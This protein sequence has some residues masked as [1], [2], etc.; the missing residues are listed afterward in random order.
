MNI[1]SL[2]DMTLA[3]VNRYEKNKKKNTSPLKY[4]LYNF[5]YNNLGRNINDSSLGGNYIRSISDI[6]ILKKTDKKVKSIAHAD[7][8]LLIKEINS[9]KKING[10]TF[11]TIL[12]NV[13]NPEGRFKNS[14]YSFRQYTHEYDKFF[15][16][17]GSTSGVDGIYLSYSYK[18]HENYILVIKYDVKIIT[19]ILNKYGETNEENSIFL[20]NRQ[21]LFLYHTLAYLKYKLMVNIDPEK[22]KDIIT[23]YPHTR[24]DRL[25]PPETTLCSAIET[26]TE[27][28]MKSLHDS[29]GRMVM[30]RPLDQ[31]SDLVVGVVITDKKLF[32]ISP[33]FI[34]MLILSLLII[35]LMIVI[36]GKLKRT[37]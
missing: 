6:Y 21:C 15:W 18:T 19:E 7:G 35:I 27:G 31:F 28:E 20:A 37:S 25:N 32:G 33:M 36:M 4:I 13:K 5:I 16:L 8:K 14:D 1:R 3:E 23:Q 9:F 34:L 30:L 24:I 17:R 29:K 22:Y 2:A 26:I 12:D 10:N 11:E